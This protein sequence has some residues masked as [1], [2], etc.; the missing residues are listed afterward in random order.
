TVGANLGFGGQFGLAV[1][2]D[3][4]FI[5]RTNGVSGEALVGAQIGVEV[6]AG[7]SGLRL[8]CKGEQEDA[9]ASAPFG[10]S[11]CH[12]LSLRK[13]TNTQIVRGEDKSAGL[14]QKK[15]RFGLV[16]QEKA[17]NVL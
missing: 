4:Y 15:G 12:V 16:K 13:L 5:A 11:Q 2:R 8:R 7:A 3:A 9:Q 14:L 10:K 1:N 6:V 17:K